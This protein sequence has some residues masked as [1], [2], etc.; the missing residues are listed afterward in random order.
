[1]RQ[2]NKQQQKGSFLSSEAATTLS[3]KAS[4][5]RKKKKK[6]GKRN[7]MGCGCSVKTNDSNSSGSHRRQTNTHAKPL[8]REAGKVRV[9]AKKKY[10]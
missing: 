8:C 9:E 5:C 1:V 4:Q 2:A 3:E 10:E 7:P 6:T